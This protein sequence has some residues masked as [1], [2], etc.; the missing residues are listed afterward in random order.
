MKN[1][2]SLREDCG[3]LCLNDGKC[4]HFTWT[5]DGICWMKTSSVHLRP[6]EKHGKG[7]ICGWIERT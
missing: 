3:E 5:K 1:K 2:K 7:L 6:I 4:T